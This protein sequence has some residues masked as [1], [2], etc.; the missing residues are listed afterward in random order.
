MN[1]TNTLSKLTTLET[2]TTTEGAIVASL[3][4]QQNIILNATLHCI[5][6]ISG[7][8]ATSE[9]MISWLRSCGIHAATYHEG[10]RINIPLGLGYVDVNNVQDVMSIRIG[11]RYT[12]GKWVYICHLYRCTRFAYRILYH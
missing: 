4:T 12:T 2:T 9:R 5:N 6:S 11:K 10:C 7:D 8:M 3:T 1:T